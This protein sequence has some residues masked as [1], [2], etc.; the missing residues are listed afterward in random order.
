MRELRRI[1]ILLALAMIITWVAV[2]CNSATPSLSPIETQPA[3]SP[4]QS[5]TTQPIATVE[6]GTMPGRILW[7]SE[8]G[9]SMQIWI[10]A[11]SGEDQHQL[12]QGDKT[13]TN[14]EPA[15]SPD[16][17]QIAFVTD[18]D[19]EQALQIYV[20]NADGT[21]QRPLMPFHPSHNWSPSWSPDGTQLLFQTNR[22]ED[23]NFEIYVVNIDGTGLRNLTRNPAN[24]SRPDW[25]PDGKQVVFISDRTGVKTIFVMNT[26]G[27]APHPLIGNQGECDFPRWSPNGKTILFQS[28]HETGGN[29]SLYLVDADGKNLRQVSNLAGNNY[30]PAWADDGNAIL[31]SSDSEN[32][33]WEIF[34]MDVASGKLWQLTQ[35][36]QR[37]RY[38]VWHR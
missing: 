31:F 1:P 12:T 16:G 34:R 33:D 25:S 29:F 32:S 36:G 7:H 27:S 8:R 20:M 18:R 11:G 2:A 35:G 19:D 13:G 23:A 38:P 17:Q 15:W 21:D 22:T 5:P 24:D 26:D 4:L 37:D 10:M 6:S 9:G 3:L 28:N 14:S 30:M